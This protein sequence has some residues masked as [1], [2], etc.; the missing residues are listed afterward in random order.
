MN[1]L[2]EFIEALRKSTELPVELRDKAEQVKSLSRTS[3]DQSFID[4]LDTQIQSSTHAPEWT[5]TLKQRRNAIL[6][7]CGKTLLKGRLEIGKDA[8]WIK[9]DPEAQAVIYWERY[10]GWSDRLKR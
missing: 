3:Y 8:Y 7:Y 5:E 4:L 6:P 2:N 9:V 1:E 10:E